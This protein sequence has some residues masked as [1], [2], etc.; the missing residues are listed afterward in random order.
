VNTNLD[1]A[2]LDRLLGEYFMAYLIPPAVFHYYFRRLNAI[3]A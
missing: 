1:M 2:L 3:S